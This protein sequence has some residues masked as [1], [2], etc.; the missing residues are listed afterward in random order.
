MQKYPKKR[1]VRERQRRSG[2]QG[3]DRK[4]KEQE[5]LTPV[6]RRGGGLGQF[7]LLLHRLGCR[8]RPGRQVAGAAAVAAARH[9]AAAQ[10][11]ARLLHEEARRLERQLVL[12]A[13]RSKLHTHTHSLI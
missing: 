10:V 11:G 8:H 1:G 13:Q 3:S 6:H 9:G 2:I 4:Q 12:H 5:V 7:G